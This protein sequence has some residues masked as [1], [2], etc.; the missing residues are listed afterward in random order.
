MSLSTTGIHFSGLSSGIDVESIVSQLIN[1]ERIPVQ[2]MQA[3]QAQLQARQTIFSQFRSTLIALSSA[4]SA[5]NTS[6]A[7]KVNKTSVS[8]KDVA[9]ATVSEAAVPGIYAI[10]VNSLA[11]AHKL[12]SSA[13]PTSTDALGFSGSFLIN[14]KLLEVKA[15][16]TLAQI[17]S[18]INGLDAKVAANVVSGGD[19]QNYLV[20]GSTATGAQAQIKI[21]EVG[22][23]VATSLGLIGAGTFFPSL[24]GMVAKSS[25]FGSSTANLQSLTGLNKSG[26]FTLGS[27]VITF[28]TSSDSIQTLADKINATGNHTASIV[29]EKIDGVDVFRLSIQSS[30]WGSSY[31]DSDGLLSNLGFIQFNYGNQI[32]AAADASL[33]VDGIPLTS[34][35]NTLTNVVGGMTINLQ[36]VGTST[37]TVERDTSAIKS[38]VKA[39]QDAYN[40]VVSFIR[41]NSSFDSE[42]YNTGILFGD[43]TSS[44]IEN[45]LSGMLF[46]AFGTGSLKNLA[47]I[48]FSLDDKGK[49]A[50]N[51][52]TLDNVI[53]EK[54][55][56]LRKLMMATGT[57]TNNAISFVSSSSKTKASS[58]T[59]YQVEITRV[60]TKSTVSGLTS[61][62]AP[63]TGGEIL[64]FKGALFGSKEFTLAIG[65][66]ATL[67]EV[68]DQINSD[69]RL[70]DL[71]V[72]SDD[73]G[74]LKIE[75]KRWGAAGKF[76]V[77]SNQ[78]ES[79]SNSGIGQAGGDAIDGVDI[80]G[81][82]NGEPASGNGQFLLGN[83]GNANTEGLQ[84]QYTGNTLGL[85]G[86]LVF[87]PGVTG[88]M[89]FRVS[90]FTDSVNGLLSTVD[91]TLTAQVDDIQ[92][93]IDRLT[94]QLKLHEENLRKRF[95][96]ME[97]AISR[98][99]SQG[100]QLAAILGRKN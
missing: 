80:E 30:A 87:N 56:E 83:N 10:Q 88:G 99:N 26:S 75:S 70:K 43:S 9:T 79:N 15:E 55:D 2:R 84:I 86:N 100:S 71:I 69:S 21:S 42:T 64:T 3:Q 6:G 28:D 96:A 98:M 77:I 39:F 4:A 12:T 46:E 32:V 97:D 57:S 8:N 41:D 35:S 1:L 52:A 65:A 54:P 23:G 38:K 19:G 93:K 78:D 67:T 63:S 14:G 94:E 13:Q 92:T 40:N 50:L 22:G 73:N 44:Q 47:Q 81:T 51:D 33:S 59:G 17:S 62:S 24:N 76:S 66:G 90:T 45:S 37:V 72:A 89:L 25:G 27:D 7:F 49:L 5:L 34:K 11:T 18:R 36:S 68:L 91:K 85:V 82:I 74:K 60:A 16:D 31:S 29:S 20:L 53:S 58:A 48:G 61:F 95:A